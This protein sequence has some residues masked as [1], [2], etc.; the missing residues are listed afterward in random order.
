MGMRVVPTNTYSNTRLRVSDLSHSSSIDA[1]SSSSNDWRERCN[2]L[3]S[4]FKSYII[5]KEGG[6]PKE[7]TN[8]FIHTNDN[9]SMR[10]AP[11]GASRSSGANNI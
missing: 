4:G 7:L 11:L 9:T 8:F 10:D 6:I 1:T 5:T 2:N 3:E